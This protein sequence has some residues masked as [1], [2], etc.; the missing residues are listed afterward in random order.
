MSLGREIILGA[1]PTG[2]GCAYTLAKAKQ[3]FLVVEKD[4]APGGL[5]RTLNFHS[6]LFDIGG[7][8]FLSKSEEI[9]QL[10]HDVMGDDMLQV[11][12]LSRIYYRRR[13]FNYPLSF[14]NTFWNLG[15]MESFL[16]VASYL[17]G[18]HFKPGDDNTFEG[19]IINRF[20]K[21]L[22]DIFF[23]TY[24]E[25]VWALACQDI[26]ADWAI[27]RI[28]GLSLRVAIQKMLLGMK[29]NAPKTL[30]EEFLYPRTGP[31]EFYR[32]LRNLTQALGGRFV[33]GKNVTSIKHDGQK[34]VSVE[35]QDSQ[36]G[37][38]K[39]LPVEYLF[40]SVPL[41]VLVRLLEPPPP[42]DI[43]TCAQR[44]RF[45]SL[46]V[47]NIILDKE[48]VFPDQWIYVHSPEV[49]LGRIQNHKN[50]SPAMVVDL[51]KTSLGLEYFC[52]EEDSLWNMNDMDLIDYAIEELEK[53]GIISRRHLISGFVVRRPHAY[54][55]YSLDYQ[56]NVDIIRRYLDRFCNL[57][58][59]GRGGLFRYDNSDRTLLSGIYAARNFLE[60]AN[61]DVWRG[62]LEDASSIG[63]S[64]ANTYVY[65]FDNKISHHS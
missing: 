62:N 19:W 42:K 33:F 1:G 21:R 11:R 32:R 13:Y 17:R 10:W 14:F 44:L 46:L 4:D 15:P 23:K 63:K 60:K 3:S 2:M 59:M 43:L 27:Q 26:S 61:Y 56:E 38:D 35:I 49:R 45:R 48:D 41:P 58:T 64:K 31:G 37:K 5:C 20:G 51:K 7:H 24:T 53:I 18:K 54:P 28:Q 47:V 9:N 50:W 12:R 39:E 55:V 8:R 30:S 25:K 65:G 16:C 6:Y 40:S 34:I 57:Q 22:Y 29:E 52:T 36:E